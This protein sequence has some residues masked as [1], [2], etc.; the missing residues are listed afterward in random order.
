MRRDARRCGGSRRERVR[1]GAQRPR[2]IQRLGAGRLRP[3]RPGEEQRGE[4]ERGH[5][6]A[7]GRSPPD[8]TSPP[9]LR[10][11]HA[12]HL[13][14]LG[15]ELGRVTEPLRTVPCGA[16]P[17]AQ[18]HDVVRDSAL[19]SGRTQRPRQPVPIARHAVRDV[20]GQQR[21]ELPLELPDA[22]ERPRLGANALG[23]GAGRPP[24]REP[25]QERRS[26]EQGEPSPRH[27]ARRELRSPRRRRAGEQGRQRSRGAGL[28]PRRHGNRA[29]RRKRSRVAPRRHVVVRVAHL[30][31]QER[32]RGVG[33]DE[34]VKGLGS[35]DPA[36]A[37]R[38]PH[39][40]LAGI[41]AEPRGPADRGLG[42]ERHVADARDGRNDVQRLAHPAVRGRDAHVERQALGSHSLVGCRAPPSLSA[43]RSATLLGQGENR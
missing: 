11:Q 41:G 13:L 9:R 20:T 2:L 35:S 39:P 16:Q 36:V 37:R 4:A 33:H 14:H 43:S 12:Q 15:R 19:D 40:R 18:T 34:V 7:A 25:R 26:N 38:Q 42:P 23:R 10:A 8:A 6:P 32:A 17:V 24:P 28:R 27:E 3:R 30:G 5:Q 21:V 1:R 31:K 29:R 22:C